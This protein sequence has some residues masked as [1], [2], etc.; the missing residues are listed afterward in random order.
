MGNEGRRRVLD[1][2]S[3][4]AGMA[5]LAHRFGLIDERARAA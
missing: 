2:F 1:T 4:E 5:R 3:F